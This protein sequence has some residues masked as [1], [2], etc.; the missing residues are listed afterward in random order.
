MLLAV[1][2]T[3]IRKRRQALSQAIRPLSFDPTPN[4][5]TRGDTHS[6]HRD[7]TR[8]S[9]ESWL[10]GRPMSGVSERNADVLPAMTETS[11]GNRIVS[12]GYYPGYTVGGYT[13]AH[14]H[15]Y[16]AQEDYPG[17][18]AGYPH[19]DGSN[20]AAY[21]AA[22]NASIYPQAVGTE[23]SGY[24]DL[25]RGPSSSSGHSGSSY[26]ERAYGQAYDGTDRPEDDPFRYPSSSSRDAMASTRWSG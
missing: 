12:D 10:G 24:A 8:T 16:A 23:V 26:G 4:Y 25:Q 19:Y 18:G 5:G 21:Q 15:G 7:M 14:Q 9:Q 1:V 2:F 3:I 13:A 11:H 17:A 22:Q 20:H 6:T